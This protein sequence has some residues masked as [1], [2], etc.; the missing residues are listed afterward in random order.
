VEAFIRGCAWEGT[1][2]VPYPRADPSD[3][4]RLPG[5][6]WATAQLP[7]GVRVEFVGDAAEVEIEYRTAT[8][9][10]T[11]GADHAFELWRS[12][13]RVSTA[14]AVLGA[15]VAR[16]A[17]GDGDD[18]CIVYLP[19]AMQP[20]VLSVTPVGGSI[21]PAPLQR[22]WLVYGDSIAEG[23][24]ASRPSG[25]WPAVAGRAGGLDVV[26]CGYAGAAR[27]EIASAEQL[28]RVTADVISVSH[29]TNCWTRTPHSAAMVRA[30]MAAFLTV[31][32]QGHPATPIVVVSPVLRPDAEATANRLGATLADLRAAIEEVAAARGD[33]TLVPGLPLL[34]ASL[35]A[36][37]IHPGDEGHRVLA[38]AIGA[39]V[40]DARITT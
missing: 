16:L 19:D 30:G 15:G 13:V 2:D 34:D 20:T 24:V 7:V 36:D 1:T 12:G 40:R 4:L 11:E 27:G 35:L 21:E 39:V 10:Y 9:G 22:R 8:A 3:A 38:A 37:G 33:V 32:R 29:G 17:T 18:R 31:L 6:T 28:A 5:D 25:A 14:P 23:W 26:N